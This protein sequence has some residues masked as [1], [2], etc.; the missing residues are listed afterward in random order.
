MNTLAK[1]IGVW[2]E[3]GR[4]F[5]KVVKSNRY[6]ALNNRTI[7]LLMKGTIDASTI[8][9]TE[10]IDVMES[11]AEVQLLM[12]LE[13]EVEIFVVDKNKTR[14]GGAFFNCLNNTLFD[15]DK[16]GIFKK[17]DRNN[18]NHNCLYL[19]LEA[20]GLSVIKLQQLILT[21]RNRT[22][23]KCD[24]S[25]VCDVLEIHIELISIR[26]DGIS[27]VEHYGNITKK[28]II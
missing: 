18:Y 8:V 16:Y 26:D 22:I 11:D 6:Y 17:V 15:F 24:L 7:A 4:L 5:M 12:L 20:G 3:D 10:T 14:A 21:L 25:N 2:S 23:H 28:H 27:R 13:T 9:G 1:Q 19:A